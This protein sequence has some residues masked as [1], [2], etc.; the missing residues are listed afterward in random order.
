WCLPRTTRRALSPYT[1]LF[2]S[3]KQTVG[4][5]VHASPLQGLAVADTQVVTPFFS[6]LQRQIGAHPVQFLGLH[7]QYFSVETGVLAPH[8]HVHLI[9][10]DIDAENKE[11]LGKAANIQAFALTN[12]IEVGPVVLPYFFAVAGM[13]GLGLSQLLQY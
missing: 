2:R 8:A 5:L 9:V 6:N 3:G 7:F 11:G 4:T 10:I 13:I 12:G 1:P